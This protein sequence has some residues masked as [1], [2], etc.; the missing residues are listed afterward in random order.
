MT[1]ILL[2]ACAAC[3]GFAVFVVLN[4]W[5]GRWD[6]RRGRER[7]EKIVRPSGSGFPSAENRTIGFV[8]AR[9]A[10]DSHL[11]RGYRTRLADWTRREAS[12]EGSG[13]ERIL[14]LQAVAGLG[15]GALFAVL[16]G[17]LPAA[18]AAVVVGAAIPALRLREKALLRERRILAGVPDAL[19]GFA[20]CVEAGLTLDQAMEHYHRDSGEGPLR[21][22]FG[23]VLNATRAGSS[24]REAL[25]A[26]RDRLGLPDI[27]LFVTTVVNAERTGAAVSGTLKRLSA[28]LRDKQVQRA[29]K[30]VQEMP[31]KMLLPLVLCIMPVTF[32]VLF[33]PVVLQLFR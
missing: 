28:I 11:L 18:L 16:T 9:R 3:S 14:V 2:A 6:E 24:R 7:L 32:L 30:A 5:I 10:L 4:G 33:G 31:V 20:L 12:P 23:K 29:E 15:A 21:D 17:S 8:A 27:S 1:G 22:E 13:P 26:L 19:E 25:T